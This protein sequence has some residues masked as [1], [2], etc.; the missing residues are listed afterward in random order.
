MSLIPHKEDR[1]LMPIFP[2]FFIILA[3]LLIRHA[4]SHPRLIRFYLYLLLF[5]E[6]TT[7]SIFTYFHKRSWEG[8]KWVAAQQPLSSVYVLT[9][10]QTAYPLYFHQYAFVSP[11]SS[12]GDEEKE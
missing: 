10:Y 4:E 8:A 3:R 1:F 2:A 12:G 11:F 6:V 5:I 7:L 9:K